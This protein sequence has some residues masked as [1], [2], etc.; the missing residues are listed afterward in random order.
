MN[1]QD[2][3]HGAVPDP[4]DTRD[5]QFEKTLGAGPVMTDEEWAEGFDV[6]EKLGV[7]IPIKNQF[8]SYSCVGQSFAYY[9]ATLNAKETGVYD[10][11]SAKSIY[12]QIALGINRGANFRDG[13]KLIVDWGSAF[14]KLIKS[15]KADGTTD[16]QF[17]FDKSWLTPEITETAKMLKA[18]SYYLVTGTGIDYFAR[19][20]KDGYGMVAGVEGCNNGTWF[21]EEPQPPAGD[22]E[23]HWFHAL[24]FGK[25]GID[26]KGKYIATPNSWGDRGQGKWQK[27]RE[28]WF[29]NENRWVFNPWVLIDKPNNKIMNL[30]A[31]K[32]K[33][34]KNIW[35]CN[36][37]TKK[38][39]VF[40]DMPS[41][42]FFTTEFQE[43]DN[44][45]D[46]QIYGTNVTLERVVTD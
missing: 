35:L 40:L 41:M 18:K 36:E 32:I 7:K 19:A 11:A 33:G 20:I 45:D 14:E 21:S 30:T 2:L 26:E 46:Y 37:D 17:M 22:T 6:E 1:E 39:E 5:Y 34:D 38:R 43:V 29:V 24:F 12:S 9:V 23:P 25:F 27:F 10:E 31:K 44:L 13:A 3:Q 15:Y 42:V 8:S 16:E 4:L 28:N